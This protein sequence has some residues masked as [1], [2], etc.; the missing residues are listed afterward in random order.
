MSQKKSRLSAYHQPLWL[1]VTYKLL[2]LPRLVRIVIVGIFAL[3]TTLALSPL[4]DYIYLSYMY[5]EESRLFPSLVSAG[6]GLLVYLFGWWLFVGS[7]DEVPPARRA[8]LLYVMVGVLIV[9]L[10]IVLALAGFSSANA[11]TI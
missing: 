3:S 2:K 8:L 9:C 10:L 1:D 5:T 4:V 6:A 11:P 7:V